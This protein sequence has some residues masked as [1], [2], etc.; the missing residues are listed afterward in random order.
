MLGL[1]TRHRPCQREIVSPGG[2]NSS[3]KGVKLKYKIQLRTAEASGFTFM[4][5]LYF[6]VSVV[7]RL[8]R[9]QLL[10]NR[11][12]NRARVGTRVIASSLAEL[13]VRLLSS[14]PTMSRGNINTAREDEYSR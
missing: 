13:F 9:E 4:K 1:K 2:R 14:P 3:N 8:E 5:S 6:M 11:P 7:R 12:L 10:K